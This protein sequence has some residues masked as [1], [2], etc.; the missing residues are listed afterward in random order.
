[1]VRMPGKAH[2]GTHVEPFV[3]SHDLPATIL[4]LVGI[5]PPQP[6]QGRCVWPLV[7]GEETDL[8]GDT[9]ISAWT[10]RACVRDREWA[11]IIDTVQPDAE[12]ELFHSAE[13]PYEGKNVAADHPDIV[14]DRRR[15]LEDFLGGPL[16]F[17]YE[18]NV[19]RRSMMTM[20]RHLEIRRRLGM[21]S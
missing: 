11:Y 2:A 7:T 1:M 6:I 9:I 12:A 3:L 10:S 19:D 5:E 15:Q 21:A 20:A 17:E 8:H 16:P 4:H 14:R 18:H 13:D